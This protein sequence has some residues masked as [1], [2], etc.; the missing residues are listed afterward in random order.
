MYVASCNRFV[1]IRNDFKWVETFFVTF[2]RFQMGKC[3][4]AHTRRRWSVVRRRDLQPDRK[5]CKRLF[6]SKNHLSLVATI[7][8]NNLHRLL[9]KEMGRYDKDRIAGLL[10]L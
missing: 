4:A 9:V 5:V 10:V 6:L 3:I 8:S 7:F 2:L 1:E